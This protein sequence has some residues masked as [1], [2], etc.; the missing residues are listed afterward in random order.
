MQIGF[1]LDSALPRDVVTINPHY[2]GDDPQALADRVKANLAGSAQV[3]A[4]VPFTI[5]VYDAQKAPPS[6][7]LAT[8]TQ[9][10]GNSIS[11]VP[12][13]IALC[14]SYYSSW[15]RP[16]Y[17][18]RLYIPM[19]FVGGTLALRPTTTQ[20]T[21]AG[22][23]ATILTS[24]LPAGHNWVLYSKKMDKSYGV[25][26]WWVDDEWDVQRSRGLR[27]TTRT[28]GTLP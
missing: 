27:P 16:G 20:R 13:E 21:N 23:W 9:G 3:G 12:R 1:P 17:R 26:N 18:G 2:F 8:A 19:N 14:L 11:G 15:N 10:T 4:T 25:T 22:N 7:P 5:R 24:G 28:L 6:Y